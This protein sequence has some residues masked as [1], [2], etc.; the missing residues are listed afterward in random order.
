MIRVLVADDHSLVR[1]GVRALL[2]KEA[3]IEVIGE[4]DNG[5][6]AVDLTEQLQPDLVIMDISMPDLDGILATRQIKD[7]ADAPQVLILSMYANRNLVQ[8][9]LR[10]GADGYL[11]KRTVSDELLQAI[12]R[13]RH[14]DVFLSRSLG[15]GPLPAP[16][17]PNH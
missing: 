5:R 2:D 4:A 3:E 1:R 13:I 11:L 14:G 8:Q 6:E 16:P 12:Q 9:A 10:V 17:T 7:L 15:S